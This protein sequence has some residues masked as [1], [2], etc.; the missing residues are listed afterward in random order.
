VGAEYPR[1]L[2]NS[3]CSSLQLVFTLCR[4]EKDGKTEEKN[5]ND[6]LTL[7]RVVYTTRAAI[8]HYLSFWGYYVL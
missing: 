1:F 2:Q 8:L 6:E 5:Q 4:E 3:F 7:Q